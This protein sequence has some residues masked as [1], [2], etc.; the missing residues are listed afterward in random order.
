M[1]RK[2]VQPNFEFD[3]FECRFNL[4]ETRIVHTNEGVY[5]TE[6]TEV[7]RCSPWATT[8]LMTVSQDW[9][10]TFPTCRCPSSAPIWT[11]AWSL[12]WICPTWPLHT[13]WTSMESRSASS[14]TSHLTPW[15]EC[16]L[17]RKFSLLGNIVKVCLYYY[18]YPISIIFS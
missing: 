18:P 9:L 3:L 12:T 4:I 17:D 11:L 16:Q 6:L 1:F 8:S 13:S 2:S 7:L 5:L 10:L 15:W 14:D